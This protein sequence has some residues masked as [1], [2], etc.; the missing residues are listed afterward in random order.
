MTDCKWHKVI[1]NTISPSGD[2]LM[3]WKVLNNA[4]LTRDKLISYAMTV[5]SSCLLCSGNDE[6]TLHLF[7]HCPYVVPLW[8][9]V[10]SNMGLSSATVN[11]WEVV[12]FAIDWSEV[13]R[14]PFFFSIKKLLKMVWHERNRRHFEGQ[15]RNNMELWEILKNAIM[16]G[17]KLSKYDF[18]L[19][20]FDPWIP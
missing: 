13:R 9:N 20:L 18:H 10:L 12:E 6:S 16:Y 1:W 7:F 3:L 5:P 15:T 2:N 14:T 8:N 17:M 4:L 19:Q 11:H